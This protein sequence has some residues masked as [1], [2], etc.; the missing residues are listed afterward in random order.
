MPISHAVSRLST[1]YRRHGFRAS[2]E[3]AWLFVRRQR[4][5]DEAVWRVA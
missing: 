3:G 2:V 5:L 4:Q 1:Y